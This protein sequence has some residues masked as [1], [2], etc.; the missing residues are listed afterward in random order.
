[1]TPPPMLHDRRARSDVTRPW[2]SREPD[3]PIPRRRIEEDL[4]EPTTTALVARDPDAP[5]RVA[6]RTASLSPTAA[7]P[8]APAWMVWEIAQ[9]L[10]ERLDDA[11]N[12]EIQVCGNSV[13]LYGIVSSSF[14]RLL[15]EDLVYSV[16]EVEECY[17]ELVVQ[18]A[19][20]A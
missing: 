9:L 11:S 8:T 14:N 13:V 12:I 19:A 7:L 4:L 10:A 17:N 20:C 18:R 6:R 5:V 15:A 3:A 16:P 2:R 1:M